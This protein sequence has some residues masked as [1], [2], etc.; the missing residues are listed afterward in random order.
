MITETCCEIVFFLP[1]KWYLVQRD[2][3]LKKE[4]LIND[5]NK[6]CDGISAK[7]RLEKAFI[8]ISPCYRRKLGPIASLYRLDL[9]KVS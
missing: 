7:F 3:E 5:C 1:G 8:P 6:Y 2:W 4:L 9:T